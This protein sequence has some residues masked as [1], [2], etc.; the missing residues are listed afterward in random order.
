MSEKELHSGG[1]SCGAVR[2]ET[3]GNPTRV[4]VCHCRYC[5]TRTGSAF[6]MNVYFE[7]SQIQITSGELKDYSFFN[8]AKRQFHN[9]FCPNGGTTV[10]WSIE[11]R[12]GWD[13]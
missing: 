7:D 11:M 1:C 5:Q 10:F 12:P 3:L 9:R 6:G 4:A 8:N 2:Y 13:F